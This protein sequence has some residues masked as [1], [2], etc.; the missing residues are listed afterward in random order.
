MPKFK[1]VLKEG[2]RKKIP[3]AKLHLLPSGFQRIGDIIVLHIDRGLEAYEK[4]IGSFV[5]KK[6]NVKSVFK[7][8][9]VSGNFRVP[10][11]KRIAG[12]SS[13]TIHRE[14][15][16]LFRIDVSRL[17]FAKGNSF[18]RNRIQPAD[19]EDVVD[20]FAGLGYFS[21]PAAR[22]NPSCRVYSV[23]K[24]P[25]AVKFL[26]ENVKLNKISNIEVIGGDCR[27]AGLKGV[28]IIMGF[29]PG[30]ESYLPA[31]FSFLRSSGVIHYHNIYR[32]K[33]LW[34]KPFGTLQ[35][36][37]LENGYRLEKVI[38]ARVVKQYS[39]CKY[40]IVVDAKFVRNP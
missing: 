8:G 15:G 20:M 27:D 21:I 28:R 34:R 11:M 16:C 23:E 5:R 10:R 25:V 12:R 2:L 14:N 32:K 35:S 19:G 13:V 6:F 40:H 31:A 29:F 24:N 7:K 37:A 17:M 18:E 22:K 38:S 3:P 4:D 36:M 26:R 30:T 33:E 39:P 1:L 9:H